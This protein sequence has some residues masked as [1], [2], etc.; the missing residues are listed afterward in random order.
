MNSVYKT[1]FIDLFPKCYYY[2]FLATKISFLK[3]NLKIYLRVQ[4]FFFFFTTETSK[5]VFLQS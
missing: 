5:P 4:L 3:I 1:S 2:I